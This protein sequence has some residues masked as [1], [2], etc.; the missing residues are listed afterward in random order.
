M[1]TAASPAPDPLSLRQRAHGFV[2]LVGLAREIAPFARQLEKFA[3]QFGVRRG[4]GGRLRRCG[5]FTELVASCHPRHM[6]DP[7]SRD[8]LLRPAKAPVR[9]ALEFGSTASRRFPAGLP[10]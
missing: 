8:N 7:I 10:I 3:L 5:P 6:A 2:I 1:Q 9:P 4:R